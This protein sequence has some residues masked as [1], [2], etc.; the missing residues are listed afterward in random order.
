MKKEELR[1]TV[2]AIMNRDDC[3][4]AYENLAEAFFSSTVSDDESYRH[5]GCLLLSAFLKDDVDAAVTA[6]C[7]WSLEELLA[8][9]HVIPDEQHVFYDN[10]VFS[11]HIELTGETMVIAFDEEYDKDK[12]KEEIEGIYYSWNHPEEEDPEIADEIENSYPAKFIFN[13]LADRGYSVSNY[14]IKENSKEPSDE[15]SL[16]ESEIKA[17]NE[18]NPS[19]DPGIKNLD[20]YIL[21]ENDNGSGMEYRTKEEF[22]K[23]IS[24]MIDDCVANGGTRFDVSIDSDA[25]C[26]YQD[27][28]DETDD[29]S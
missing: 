15:Q 14:T 7:G 26:F 5:I 3:G 10:F 1:K 12:L 28:S 13:M 16:E 11:F 21:T 24:L 6:L 29:N 17:E 8:K 2:L 20:F 4:E 18:E 27:E 9:A 25:S 19:E 22:M 23:E